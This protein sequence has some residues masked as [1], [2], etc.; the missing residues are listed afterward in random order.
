[1]ITKDLVPTSGIRSFA[2]MKS[3]AVTSTCVTVFTMLVSPDHNPWEGAGVKC[4]NMSQPRSLDI[5]AA[6]E[7]PRTLAVARTSGDSP[8]PPASRETGTGRPKTH[9]QLIVWNYHPFSGG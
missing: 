2:I 8:F 7:L 6:I 5:E 1:M 4:E 9:D 3:L